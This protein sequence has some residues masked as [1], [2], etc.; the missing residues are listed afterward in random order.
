MARWDSIV[1]SVAFALAFEVA[2]YTSFEG[3]FEEAYHR[4]C[5]ALRE[6]SVVAYILLVS[7]AVVGI[8]VA[9]YLLP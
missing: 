2:D 3:P 7:F 8:A 1:A 4:T 5:F 9:A 6:A